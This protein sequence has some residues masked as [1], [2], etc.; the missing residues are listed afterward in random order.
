MICTYNTSPPILIEENAACIYRERKKKKIKK[1]VSPSQGRR[2][3][4]GG[5]RKDVR[6]G[7]WI[8]RGLGLGTGGGKRLKEEATPS[9]T[10]RAP[11]FSKRVEK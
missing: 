6:V 9:P 4:E 1:R 7:V 11:G 5:W 10:G 3:M 2:N 8:S